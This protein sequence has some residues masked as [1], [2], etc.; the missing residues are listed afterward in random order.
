M[1]GKYTIGLNETALGIVAP[2]WFMHTMT[3]TIP[4]RQAELALTT[5]RMFSVDEAL[6]V[7]LIYSCEISKTNQVRVR[8]THIPTIKNL[9]LVFIV[10]AIEI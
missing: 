7:R 6:K 5:A 9:L 1:S 8:L 10:D 3:N 2:N 4:Q